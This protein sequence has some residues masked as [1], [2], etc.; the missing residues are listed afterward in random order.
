M[1][2]FGSWIRGAACSVQD[3]QLCEDILSV[4]V[5]FQLSTS[6]SEA[7]RLGMGEETRAKNLPPR[8]RIEV[9]AYSGDSPVL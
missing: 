5:A 9:V 4:Q 1:V 7:A 8:C 6:L 3:K 2:S